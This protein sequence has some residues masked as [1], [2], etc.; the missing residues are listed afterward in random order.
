MKSFIVLSMLFPIWV[1]AQTPLYSLGTNSKYHYFQR[2][3]VTDDFRGTQIRVGS[4][5]TLGNFGLSNS[6]WIGSNA[7]LDYSSYGDIGSLGNKNMFVPNWGPGAALVMELDYVDGKLK[8]YNHA[9]NNSTDKVDFAD[10]EQIWEFG[11]TNSYFLSNLGIGTTNP[12]TY[13]LAVKG[14]ILA[15]EIKVETGWAD[16]VFKEDYDLP[17]LQEVEKH[18]KEKGHLINIPSAQEVKENGIEL[19]EMNKLLLE[20]I[21]EL[22][23]Y[24]IQQ[25]KKLEGIKELKIQNRLLFENIQKLEKQITQIL[26]QKNN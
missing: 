3:W 21:E 15:E 23:L 18:I 25:E 14:K 7:I 8:G 20:K 13:K 11:K 6:S 4:Y 12:G 22:T 2:N 1:C 26:E 16:Y 24:C 19:G 5:L 17:T 10:F 9:W